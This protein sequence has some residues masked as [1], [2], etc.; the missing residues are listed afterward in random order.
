MEHKGYDHALWPTPRLLRRLSEIAWQLDNIPYGPDRRETLN[1]EG[2]Y[3]EWEVKN[4][5]SHE[6]RQYPSPAN[7]PKRIGEKAI[8]NVE[9]ISE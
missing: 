5:R 6:L 4:Y 8:D 9:D 7:M 1:K 2:D 3:I